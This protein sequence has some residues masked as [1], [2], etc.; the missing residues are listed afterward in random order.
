MCCQGLQASSMPSAWAS[1]RC[2]QVCVHQ[3]LTH[4]GLLKGPTCRA[5]KTC[6]GL[7]TA[8]LSHSASSPGSQHEHEG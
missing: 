1:A 3:N 7:L 5:L 6:Q 4:V 8:A 2:P